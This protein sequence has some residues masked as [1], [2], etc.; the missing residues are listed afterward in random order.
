MSTPFSVR[1]F[2]ELDLRRVL[3]I[4]RAGFGEWAWDRN[5]FAEY[6]RTCGGGFLVALEGDKVVGYCIACVS[7]DVASVESIAVAPAVRGRGAADV[8]LRSAL[9][10]LRN[11]GITRV[12]LMV[13]VTNERARAFYEKFGFRK[14]RRVPRYYEDGADGLLMRLVV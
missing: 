13:K 3:A 1:R 14:I 4:E 2:R 10:R 6:A 5:L 12:S 11:Q 7:R 8:L 9:K